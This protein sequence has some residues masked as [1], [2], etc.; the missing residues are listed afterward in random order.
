MGLVFL[1]DGKYR[2]RGTVRNMSNPAKIDPLKKAFGEYF[3]RLELVEAD[4]LDEQSILDA[5]AGST[6]VIHTASPF[7]FQTKTKEE[8]IKPAV[9]GTLAVMKACKQQQQHGTTSVKRVVITSSVAA[10]S[11]VADE[12][13]PKDGALFDETY[14]S[15]PNR[16]GGI[17]PYYESKTLAE[18]AAWEFQAA[19]PE[20]ERFE[21]STINPVFIM[22]PSICAGDGTSEAWMASALDGSKTKIP[23]GA[24]SFVDVRDCAIAHLKAMEIPEAANKRFLL[25]EGQHYAKDAYDVLAAKYNPM[26]YKVPTEEETRR[27][28]DIAGTNERSKKVLGIEYIPFATTVTDM[29]DSMI[30]AGKIKVKA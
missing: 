25:L 22:G 19:L 4:L 10:V 8:L 27:P 13:K 7:F 9:D 29:V 11:S 30:A 24:A 17:S 1:K 20:S 28:A 15:D 16:P 23:G 26:G 14:W 3:D 21:I 2:I 18:R 5:I 6:Y 12:D